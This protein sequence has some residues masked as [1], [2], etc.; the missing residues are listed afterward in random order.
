MHLIKNYWYFHLIG[1]AK[2]GLMQ[3]YLLC[4]YHLGKQQVFNRHITF[5]YHFGSI[6]S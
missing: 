3:I 6:I 4:V 2:L 5:T 1:I